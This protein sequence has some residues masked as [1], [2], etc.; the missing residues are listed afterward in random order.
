MSQITLLTSIETE[1][2]GK[3]PDIDCQLFSVQVIYNKHQWIKKLY[4]IRIFITLCLI[5][6]Y[7]ANRK[8]KIF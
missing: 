8:E 7:S 4:G 2:E 1:E 5:I 3:K 6:I